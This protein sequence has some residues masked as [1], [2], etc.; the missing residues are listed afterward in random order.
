MLKTTTAAILSLVLAATF[1]SR[2]TGRA[3]SPTFTRWITAWGTSPQA[4]AATALSHTTVRLNARVTI[5]GDAVRL[6]LDNSYGKS[7]V[8]IGRAYVGVRARGPALVA[9]SNKPAL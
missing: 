2:M 8:K 9:G 4:A 1:S 3:Q 5:G 7:D 6:R